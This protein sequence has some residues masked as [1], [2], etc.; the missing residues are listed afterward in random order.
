MLKNFFAMP[1]VVRL[2][3]IASLCVVV[4]AL[5]TMFTHTS[6]QFGDRRITSTA[7][8]NIGAGPFMLI[9]ALLMV[10]SAVMMLRRSRYARLAHIVAWIALT[11][12]IPFVA[13]VT[14]AKVAASKPSLI[15]NGLLTLAMALYLYLSKATRTYFRSST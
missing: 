6:I 13:G 2:F 3:T 12:S 10:A 8:W 1:T 9:V 14:G 15:I 7:W 11:I 5:A 4:F